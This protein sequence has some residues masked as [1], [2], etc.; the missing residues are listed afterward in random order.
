MGEYNSIHQQNNSFTPSLCEFNDILS[1]YIPITDILN[2]ILIPYI[3][4]SKFESV[5]ITSTMNIRNDHKDE[6]L[7][8]IHENEE[9]FDK[10]SSIKLES[11]TLYDY[12]YIDP[13]NGITT[14]ISSNTT[15]KFGAIK[16]DSKNAQ[17]FD[18][19]KPRNGKGLDL[20]ELKKGVGAKPRWRGPQIVYDGR[21]D[22]GIYDERQ[23]L[24]DLKRKKTRGKKRKRRNRKYPRKLMIKHRRRKERKKKYRKNVYHRMTAKQKRLKLIMAKGMVKRNGIW[25]KGYYGY[26]PSYCY[27]YAKLSW[28]NYWGSSKLDHNGWGNKRGRTNKHFAPKSGRK[29]KRLF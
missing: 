15:Y 2:G 13:F 19:S 11:G 7:K 4:Y 12:K 17:Y 25:S 29:H 14:Y 26:C 21:L 23:R 3:G 28:C 24:K 16:Y 5:V 27:E 20:R 18:Y 10:E 9:E 22:D 1:E 6:L 8:Q